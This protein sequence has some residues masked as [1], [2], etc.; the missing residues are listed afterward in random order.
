MTEITS[1]AFPAS[2]KDQF[3]ASVAAFETKAKEA[4]E[5]LLV[6]ARDIAASVKL[7]VILTQEDLDLANDTTKD[8]KRKFK[9]TEERRT[10]ITKPINEGLRRVNAVFKPLLDQY[11][12]SESLLKQK[13]AAGLKYLQA[14]QTRK[15]QEVAVLSQAGDMVGAKAMLLSTPDAAL[16]SGT[17]IREILKYKVVDISKVPDEYLLLVVNDAAVQ[18]ALASGAKEIPGIEIYTE[19]SVTTRTG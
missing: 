13:V 12:Q 10:S 19:D 2:S 15:L 3:L 6:E 16:P 18:V 11:S 9:D 1:L 4:L 17:S 14:E 8:V 5:P 7:F